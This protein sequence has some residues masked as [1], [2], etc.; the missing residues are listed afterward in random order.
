MIVNQ[1]Y[2]ESRQKL[3]AVRGEGRDKRGTFKC[4]LKKKRRHK[5]EG[6]K[7]EHKKDRVDGENCL[8]D[9]SRSCCSLFSPQR[10]ECISSLRNF[11]IFPQVNPARLRPTRT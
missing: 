1:K 8:E 5:R 11:V 10:D 3:E 9:P 4:E 2:I 6:K 7:L